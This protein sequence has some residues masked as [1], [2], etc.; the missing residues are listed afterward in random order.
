M[1]SFYYLQPHTL[2]TQVSVAPERLKAKAVLLGGCF[3]Q[4]PSS[5]WVSAQL[6]LGYSSH[7]C[8]DSYVAP[9]E[10]FMG[11]WQ[12]PLNS[13]SPSCWEAHFADARSSFREAHGNQRQPPKVWSL[14]AALQEWRACGLELL[15]SV[16][17]WV[18][19]SLR[20]WQSPTDESI[21][22]DFY[23][24]SACM[25]ILIHSQWRPVKKVFLD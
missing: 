3:S 22:E 16:L 17:L 4:W 14:G 12:E 9:Q 7:H 6:F 20:P 1:H 2:H 11:Q 25:M 5:G 23:K 21:S 10:L 8:S 18:C 19:D 15:V 13:T 24:H